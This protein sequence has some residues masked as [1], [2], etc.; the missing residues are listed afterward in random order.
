MLNEIRLQAKI[1]WYII[2]FNFSLLPL[3]A[4]TEDSVKSVDHDTTYYVNFPQKIQLRLYLSRKYTG[5]LLDMVAGASRLRYL[6]NTPINLGAGFTYK[7]LTINVAHGFG[8][9]NPERGRGETRFLDLQSHQYFKKWNI[10]LFGQFYRGYYLSNPSANSNEYVRPDL[11]VTE[12]GVMAQYVFNHDKFSFRAAYLNTELQKKSAGTWLLGGN[13][14]Y[15]QVKSDSSLA[16][17]FIN[18]NREFQKVRFIKAGPLGGYAY[19]LVLAKNIYLS[20]ALTMHLNFGK[21]W[22]DSGSG[23]DFFFSHDFGLRSSLGYTTRRFSL[24]LLYLWQDVSMTTFRDVMQTG[25][26]RAV[27]TYRFVNKKSIPIIDDFSF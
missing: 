19:T 12:L 15:G 23:G 22:L 17:S 4:Q 14:F 1:L 24:S 27:F 20:A 16:P 18:A 7:W 26:V 5:V 10:D 25:N 6:P 11:G 9:L 13:I 3:A 8:F 2:L 21:S